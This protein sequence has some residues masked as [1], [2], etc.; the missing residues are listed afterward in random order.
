MLDHD[1]RHT[2]ILVIESVLTPSLRISTLGLNLMKENSLVTI[3]VLSYLILQSITISLRV[4]NVEQTGI[5][6]ATYGL[7][8]RRSPN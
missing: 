1:Y 4:A 8:S 3:T 5:E 6:P 2:R 7:Q